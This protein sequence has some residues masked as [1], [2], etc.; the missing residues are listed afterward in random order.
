[1]DKEIIAYITSDEKRVITGNPLTLVIADENERK[2]CVLDISR[3]MK[4]NVLQLKNG[5]Y[6]IIG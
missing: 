5:D 1:M 6:I 3:A 4:G 2:S